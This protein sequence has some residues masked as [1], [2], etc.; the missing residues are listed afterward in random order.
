MEYSLDRSICE[1]CQ[2]IDIKAK[3]DKEICVYV[4]KFEN[5]TCPCVNCIV[6]CVCEI[7][8]PTNIKETLSTSQFEQ[9]VE[10]T[11]YFLK[12]K[13]WKKKLNKQEI[14]KYNKERS[15]VIIQNLKGENNEN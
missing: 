13:R 4:P 15:K 7:I 11:N 6:K 14:K 5:I 12:F 3:N 2:A 9:C 10:L 1:C 8:L